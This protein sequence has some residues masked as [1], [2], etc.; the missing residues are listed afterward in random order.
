MPIKLTNGKL[1]FLIPGTRDLIPT[2]QIVD[3]SI[4]PRSVFKTN[5]KWQSERGPVHVN[6][7]STELVWQHSWKPFIFHSPPIFNDELKIVL[8]NFQQLNSFVSKTFMVER[9]IK[10]LINYTASMS[11]DPEVIYQILAGTGAGLGSLVKNTGETVGTIIHSVSSNLIYVTNGLLKG[12]IQI[13]IN[14]FV[15]CFLF[16]F[17]VCLFYYAYIYRSKLALLF[18]SVC[19]RGRKSQTSIELTRCIPIPKPNLEADLNSP[20]NL[21]LSQINNSEYIIDLEAFDRELEVPLTEIEVEQNTGLETLVCSTEFGS[22]QVGIKLDNLEVEALWDSGSSHTLIPKRVLQKLKKPLL[23]LP[24]VPART[25]TGNSLQLLGTVLLEIKLGDRKISHVFTVCEN[26]SC[27]YECIIGIDFQK[28]LGKY[29]V[30]FEKHIITVAGGVVKFQIGGNC[31]VSVIENIQIPPF[32]SV[33]L[34]ECKLSKPMCGSV[35]VEPR[36]Q[37]LA[38]RNLS[39]INV[40][41]EV[42][43]NQFIRYEITNDSP[44]S[45]VLYKHTR[46]ADCYSISNDKCV[47]R[48]NFITSGHFVEPRL[49][50]INLPT[51]ETQHIS[52]NLLDR[53]NNLSVNSDSN[54]DYKLIKSLQERCSSLG[55]CSLDE[56]AKLLESSNEVSNSF[57]KK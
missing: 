35:V 22:F 9:Q 56:K 10:H 54:D 32:S 18:Q 27:P 20:S 40:L 50:L 39:G 57:C 1:W 36:T 34:S 44:S 55:N 19:K 43:P 29:S 21:E 17:V 46:I 11:C 37:A 49:D 30:D 23:G 52:N 16:F 31:S 47:S 4:T 26:Y 6:E 14:L 24:A 48:I 38:K 28:R 5:G 7:L 51:L 2:S 41:T 45:I 42:L 13:L 12:P 3:C 53:C 33:V 25:L 8:G 15:I